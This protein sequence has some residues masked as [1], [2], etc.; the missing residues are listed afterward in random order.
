MVE[1]IIN[2]SGVPPRSYMTITSSDK[3]ATVMYVQSKTERGGPAP[4]SL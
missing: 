3:H 4:T 2:Q 1:K